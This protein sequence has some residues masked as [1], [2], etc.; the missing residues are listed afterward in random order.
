MTEEN[1]ET[2]IDFTVDE[3]RKVSV[4]IILVEAEGDYTV[5]IVG[6]KEGNVYS[7]DIPKGLSRT[8]TTE[9][10]L[11]ADHYT[12]TFTGGDNAEGETPF[13]SINVV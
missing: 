6:D 5:D 4:M 13:F 8:I 10:E 2:D 3:E 12:I 7:A 11:P 1:N 9:L